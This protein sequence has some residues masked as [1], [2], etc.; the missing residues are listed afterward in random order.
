MRGELKD[1][2][3]IKDRPFSHDVKNGQ[4]ATSALYKPG[5]RI[6]HDLL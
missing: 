2:N 4:P 3:E 1:K 6:S 5:D